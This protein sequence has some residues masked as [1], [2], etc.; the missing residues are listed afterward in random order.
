[1]TSE[2][3]QKNTEKGI[4]PRSVDYAEWYI[5]VIKAADL[6]DYA[7]VK[8][9]MVIKP[10]GYA[11]WESIQT[12]LDKEFKKTGVRNAYFPMLIPERLLKR[13]ENHVEGFAPEVAVV[14]HAGGKKLEEPL[15]VRPTS[16]TIMYEIFS[17][18]IRSYRDLPLLINQWTNV[19]RWE[20]RTRLFMRTTEFLWQEGH[21]VHATHD[22]ADERARQMLE[23][24][25]VFAEEFLAIPVIPGQKSESEKFAGALRTYTV[26][27][28]MQDGKALQFATSHNLGQNFAKAFDV[29]FLD[30]NSEMQHGWQTSWGLSTRTIGGLIM[31]H[32]D[33]KGLVLPPKVAS[34]QVV[35]TTIGPVDSKPMV[36]ARAFELKKEFEERGIR[37]E[38]DNRDIRPGEKFFD[39]E[40]KGIPVR[41]ELGPKDIAQNQTVFVRRDTGVKAIVSLTDAAVEAV[42]LLDA[43]QNDLFTVAQN[44]LVERTKRVDS[45][46]EFKKEIEAGNFALAH[47]CGDAEVEA[48]I[49]E[50]TG[51]TT[52]CIPFAEPD[53]DGVCVYS[54]K[55]SKKRVVFAKAY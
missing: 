33:D 34:T 2:E 38:V 26:E 23:I 6:A 43:I 39:H 15:V 35:I 50:E 3:S 8:G 37:V 52:R 24:Y 27:A 21:T 16:E 51:A 54:G 20:M 48:K 28:M 5:D 40:K 49:K 1:M 41:V 53:E 44:R 18:W 14:T 22:E 29:K 4:T 32:S 12:Y 42:R 9:C 46:E 19:V 11:I 7:P 36:E 25:R 31:C 45:Y 13:E 47:W 30:Q 17:G 10:N 55:P